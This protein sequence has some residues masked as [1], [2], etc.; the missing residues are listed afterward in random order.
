MKGNKVSLKNCKNTRSK[1]KK[2]IPQALRKRVKKK[3]KLL[4]VNN[5]SLTNCANGSSIKENKQCSEL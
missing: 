3:A 1:R 2:A 4:E 5:V